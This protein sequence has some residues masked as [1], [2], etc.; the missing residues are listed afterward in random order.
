M[1]FRQEPPRLG[2]QYETDRALRSYLKRALPQD[3]LE[4]IEPELLELGE[5]GGR[6]ALPHAARGPSER[7]APDAVGRVGR[8]G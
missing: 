1:P 7:A 6:R 2:N 8:A 4:E 5:L 3:V